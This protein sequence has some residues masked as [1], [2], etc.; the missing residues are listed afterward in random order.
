VTKEFLSRMKRTQRG[1]PDL[2]PGDVQQP[3]PNSDAG[4]IVTRKFYPE[5]DI[6]HIR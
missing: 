5:R 4:L 1:T 6:R 3:V 2:V